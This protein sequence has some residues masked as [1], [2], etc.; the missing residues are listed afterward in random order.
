METE[1]EL[2]NAIRS[3]ERTA[4]RRLYDRFSGYAAAI[5][6]R[7]IPQR[8]EVD[9]VIQDCFVKIL[10]SID[11]FSY[12][13]EGS[14]KS[15]ISRIVANKAVD[16]VRKHERIT[17]V[18]TIPDDIEDDPPDLGTIPPDL[19]TEMI[20]RLPANYRVV[21][22]LFVFEQRSHKDIAQK[23]GIN[24]NTSVMHF[25]RAKKMLAKMVKDYI[26]KQSI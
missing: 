16:Y 4:L 21:L 1:Q 5:A 2:L 19:L 22:N 24:E 14:L 11:S 7:Y 25:F 23:L 12:R 15:W 20:G 18:S 10:T 3:G 6:L 17:I 13:G 9:D 8:E 26:K